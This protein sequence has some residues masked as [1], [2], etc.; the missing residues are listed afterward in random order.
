M[1]PLLTGKAVIDRTLQAL[2][3][4]LLDMATQ[5]AIGKIVSTVSGGSL[6]LAIWQ[7]AHTD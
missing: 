1:Y 7:T 4:T 5:R 2:E 6:T 3:D